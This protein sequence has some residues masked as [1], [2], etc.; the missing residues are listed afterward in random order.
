MYSNLYQIH[1]MI[2]VL[3][4]MCDSVNITQGYEVL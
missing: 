4:A 2:I 1:N 3:I